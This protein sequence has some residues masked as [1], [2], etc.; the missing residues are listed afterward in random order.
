[1]RR[2][3]RSGNSG[4][5]DHARNRG[6][7]VTGG[8][9]FLQPV[10]EHVVEVAVL[11]HLALEHAQLEFLAV[12]PLDIGLALRKGALDRLLARTGYLVFF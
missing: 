6:L 9:G 4:R 10:D 8:A 1:M 7:Q 2:E 12:E 11:Q 3:W 5:I